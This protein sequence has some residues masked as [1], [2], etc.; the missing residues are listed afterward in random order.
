MK[1]KMKGVLGKRM[2]NNLEFAGRVALITGGTVA[3]ALRLQG[4]SLS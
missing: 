2:G 3:L 4:V 1:N